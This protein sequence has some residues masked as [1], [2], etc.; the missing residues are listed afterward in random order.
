MQ[1]FTTP[2]A[3]ANRHVVEGSGSTVITITS[4]QPADASIDEDPSAEC[5]DS[6]DL[7]EASHSLC[8]IVAKTKVFLE[9]PSLLHRKEAAQQQVAETR[10]QHRVSGE[11]SS[12]AATESADATEYATTSSDLRRW[13]W[14][15]ATHSWL[16]RRAGG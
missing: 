16:R 13:I 6:N 11:R 15:T 14:R 4:M 5:F 12:Q 9:R 8:F 1:Q 3:R 7:N 10:V 2:Y